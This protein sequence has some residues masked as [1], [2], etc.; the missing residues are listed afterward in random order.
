ML[1]LSRMDMVVVMVAVMVEVVVVATGGGVG[2][3]IVQTLGTSGAVDPINLQLMEL[4]R[5]MVLG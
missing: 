3:V 5:G 2:V 1:K 4:R